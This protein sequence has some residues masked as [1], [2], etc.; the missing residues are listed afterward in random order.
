MVSTGKILSNCSRRESIRCGLILLA[1][2]WG[3][4]AANVLLLARNLVRRVPNEVTAE[5]FLLSGYLPNA[6]LCLFLLF[7][8]GWNIGA[9][10]VLIACVTYLLTIILLLRGKTN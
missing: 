4:V 8:W 5:V 2:C 10:V 6:V 1:S 3:F 9:Y 7:Q